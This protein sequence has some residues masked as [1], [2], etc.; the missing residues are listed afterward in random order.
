MKTARQL[1]EIQHQGPLIL[2]AGSF[3]GMHLGHMSLVETACRQAR[4]AG[5][6]AW[7]LTFDPHP[8]RVLT[9]EQAPPLL[10]DTRHKLR[11]LRQT[12]LDGC[13]LLPFNPDF[14]HLEPE[15]FIATLR[16]ALPGWE[17]LVVGPNWRFGYQ[18][19][20]STDILQTL[21]ETHGFVAEVVKP[22]RHDGQ[23]VSSSR[24]RDSIQHGHL[25]QAASM[26]GR[27]FSVYGPVVTGK[28]IGRHL[29]FPTANVHFGA[30]VVPPAGIYAVEAHGDEGRAG[31][32]AYLGG[33]RSNHRASADIVEVHLLDFEGDLYGH[34]LEVS[35]LHFIR[36][37]QRF[38]RADD[39]RHQIN[40]DV[41]EA[42]RV[43]AMDGK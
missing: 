11:L 24:I 42:R 40:A 26:L 30:E 43:L 4:E 15:A 31:G 36:P 23:P 38:E 12:G 7:L 9:P 8:A 17:R 6:E 41:R 29:G 35:F 14:A 19:R 28:Q 34:W 22:V 2:A 27:P 18:A 25:D 5:G 39:L 32:A 1:K 10:T 3:D 20:G 16:E 33:P 13:L 37:D 21:A